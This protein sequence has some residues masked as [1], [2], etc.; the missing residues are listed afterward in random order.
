[1]SSR[2]IVATAVGGAGAPVGGLGALAQ[3][4]NLVDVDGV[5]LGRELSTRFGHPVVVEN[6]AN[7]AALAELNH[8]R[9]GHHRSFVFITVG[10]GIGMGIVI[11]GRLIRGSRGAAGE[12]GFLPFGADPLERSNQLRGPLEEVTAGSWLA[13]AYVGAT[14]VSETVP[15]IFDLA[16]TGEA[17]ALDLLDQ[18]AEHLARAI[19]AVVA[20]IDPGLVILG[21]GIGSRR[22]LLVPIQRWLGDYGHP[23]VSIAISEFGSRASV[24]GA[25]DLAISTARNQVSKELTA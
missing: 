15:R 5:D 16:A 1:M 24:V 6:D 21:G 22:E 2:S 14:G 17:D 3:A 11:D 25:V 9:G 20:V 7:M 8:G 12:I 19:V 4:P 23:G 13:R 10:T 18:E